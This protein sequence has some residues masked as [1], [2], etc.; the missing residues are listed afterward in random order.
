MDACIGYLYGHG[1]VAGQFSDFSL[2]PL[3]LDARY[4]ERQ[5]KPISLQIQRFE[6][7][8]KLNCGFLFFAPREL[9]GLISLKNCRL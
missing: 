5:D 6:V 1:L 9:M 4:S 2:N 8:L 7:D 3:V